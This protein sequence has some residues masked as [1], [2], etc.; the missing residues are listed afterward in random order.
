MKSIRSVVPPLFIALS[1]GVV[2]LG[3]MARGLTWANGGTDGGDLITAAAVG[4]VAHP[5]GYPTYLLAAGVFQ[6]IPLGTLA[7]RTHLLSAAAAVAA[8]LVVYFMVTRLAGATSEGN[9]LAGL[10]AAGLFGLAPLVWSQAVIAE[11]YTLHALFVALVAALAVWIPLKARSGWWDALLGVVLGLAVGNHL[12]SVFLIP[13]A[14]LRMK[15]P[16]PFRIDPGALARGAAGLGTGLL[17][18]AALPL[19]ALSL[20]PVNWGDPVTLERFSWLVSGQLYQRR[21]LNLPAAGMVERLEEAGGLLAAQVGLAGILLALVGLIFYF[22]P[23]RLYFLTLWIAAAFAAFAVLY[24][25]AD[26]YLYLIPVVLSLSIWAG[27]GLGGLM[28]PAFRY[29]GWFKPVAAALFGLLLVGYA[30]DRWPRVDA[31]RDGRAEQFG[32]QV[33]QNAPQSALIF[34]QDDASVFSMWYFHFALRQRP[35]LVI[36]AQDLLHF[37]W[38]DRTLRSTYPAVAWPGGLFWPQ[39]VAEA[40]PTR[41][42]CTLTSAGA[43]LACSAP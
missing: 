15:Q 43:G 17:V 32:A 13:A 25:S 34:A 30:L 4:G 10:A 27:L 40:N 29:M 1:L 14:L 6:Q 39:S 33:L 3:T 38:Y 19:R 16:R 26:S 35:D 21:L 11:V 23:T 37:E 18:Y 5:T 12:T 28:Q 41:P 8:A 20:P 31:S 7:F 22:K 24:A 2:Y 9:W 42:V 36:M